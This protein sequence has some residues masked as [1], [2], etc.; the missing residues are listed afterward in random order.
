MYIKNYICGHVVETVEL[1]KINGCVE[2]YRKLSKNEMIDTT[3]GEIIEVEN[4]KNRGEQLSSL[5]STIRRL[6]MIINAN[7]FGEP[8][9]LF[10]TLTYRENMIDVGSLF[11]DFEKF[12]KRLKRR[13]K[14]HK[15]EYIYAIEPQLRG[16]WHIHLLLK[17]V[18]VKYLY[19]PNE[20][21]AKLWGYGFTKTKRVECVDNIGAYL[22]AYLT[23]L[24]DGG[25]AAR[26]Y[27]YPSG[28]NIYRTSRGIKKPHIINGD[29]GLDEKYKVY[30]RDFE[31]K[32]GD[33]VVNRVTIKQYNFR[34][35]CS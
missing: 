3:T 34:R 23:N 24:E 27:L 26:L 13:Y 16:A 22:S 14:E 5:R 9:E 28:V 10:V 4:S 6:R 33:D 7:F 20:E 25:K 35:F 32:D 30:E 1:E 31:I 12:Y 11:R 18:N 2:R 17:A 19:I 29:M 21:I 8:N 15:F